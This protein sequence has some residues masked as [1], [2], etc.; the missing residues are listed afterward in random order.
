M[1]SICFVCTGNICRSPMAALI[2][3]EHLR[4]AGL[5]DK[6]EVSSC[7]MGG[8]HVGSPADP[9]A[10]AT[11]QRAGYP[12]EH[13]AA[14]LGEQHLAVD[15]L[16]ALDT[17]HLR[18]LRQLVDDPERVRLLRS[19]GPEEHRRLSVPDPY[20]DEDEGF[21]HVRDLIEAAM[22]GLIAWT[23]DRL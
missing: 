8:W 5:D 17:G 9:R 20:Y 23:R 16:I 22:P 3:Q 18:D 19:F 11:L 7:G 14:Q 4:R 12:T 10:V 21:E 15:L 1:V 6:V 13:L 2:F